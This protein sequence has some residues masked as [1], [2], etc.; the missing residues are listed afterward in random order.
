MYNFY[1]NSNNSKRTVSTTASTPVIE[2][3]AILAPTPIFIYITQGKTELVATIIDQKVL[4]MFQKMKDDKS[5]SEYLSSLD[6]DTKILIA[7]N[8]TG[9]KES[10]KASSVKLLGDKEIRIG[11]C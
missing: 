10:D 2:T 4:V 1:N 6:S 5:R 3:A 7:R 11:L 9:G 8:S